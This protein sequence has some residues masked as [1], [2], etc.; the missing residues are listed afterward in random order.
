MIQ[1]EKLKNSSYEALNR[2]PWFNW[3]PAGPGGPQGTPETPENPKNPDLKKHL[4]NYKSHFLQKKA[5]LTIPWLEPGEPCLQRP[6]CGGASPKGLVFYYNAFLQRFGRGQYVSEGALQGAL[7]YTASYNTVSS[8]DTNLLDNQLGT[9]N[10][11][12]Y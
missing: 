7:K 8:Y 11:L 4:K 3:G 12:G 2:Y 1:N 6:Q 9:R 5:M 10:P